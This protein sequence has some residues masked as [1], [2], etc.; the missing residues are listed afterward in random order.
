MILAAVILFVLSFLVGT[1]LFLVKFAQI[2]QRPPVKVKITGAAHHYHESLWPY[3]RQ[4]FKVLAHSFWRFILEAKD[5]APAAGKTLHT[6]TERVRSV[7]RIRVRSDKNEAVWM[8]EA[9][10]LTAQPH[11]NPEDLYLEAIK[12]NPNDRTAYE[13]LGRL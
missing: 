9:T 2:S 6:Q 8:P 10:E 11:H 1:S 13:A 12:K 3:F 5:L 7:F 4:K